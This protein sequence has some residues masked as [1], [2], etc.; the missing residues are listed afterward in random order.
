MTVARSVADVLDDH[1]TLEVECIDRMYLNL[2]VP[3]L[4]YELG[5]VGFFRNHLGLPFVSGALMDP[6]SKRF[7]ADIERF[8]AEQGVDLVTFEKGERK[9]DV[10]HEYLAAFEGEEGVLFVGKAQEKTR[11]FRTEKRKNP[12]TGKRYPWIVRATALVNQYYFYGIDGDLGP[13]FIKFSSYFPYTA[14]LCIN[15]N[16]FA[17][18]QAAKAGIAFEPLDNG[19]ASCE[20]P[21]ALQ[22]ICRKLTAAKIEALVRKWFA[23]LPHPYTAADRR[24]GYRYDLSILQAE[25]SLTQV[26]D[27]P[28][29]GRV[30]FEEVIRDNLDIG[31]P[32]QVSLIFGRRVSK[33]TPGRF[34]TRV[35][36]DGVT[37]SL[38]VDYKHSRIKQYFKLG[39]A[40]R[41][42][43]TINDA[44][45][46][47]VGN[48]LEPAVMR[49]GGEQPCRSC[50]RRSGSLRII[51]SQ[52]IE[53][54]KDMVGGPIAPCAR[55]RRGSS[56]KRT[57]F[58][59]EVGVQVHLARAG[60]LM[61]EPQCN[62]CQVTT[63]FK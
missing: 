34:R 40:I 37:P 24:A 56:S 13:F 28:L 3:R 50:V 62:S 43:M 52:S 6:I 26:L 1:V 16:E 59:R 44:G 57:L 14:K 47:G 54:S 29:Q 25:F 30:F 7:V 39:K 2:Y 45:D 41:T 31:R 15:G 23:I 22:Q 42:E 4:Q 49:N 33:R 12:E 17:K 60:I 61:T 10:A 58:E 21:V 63:A 51:A 9:D 11:T 53:E 48:N 8:C 35:L 36:T 32:D 46:F 19:F 55:V 20:D 38:H 5:V 27:R 18:A